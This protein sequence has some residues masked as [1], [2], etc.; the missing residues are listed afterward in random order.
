M[1]LL[2]LESADDRGDVVHLERPLAEHAPVQ[3]LEIVVGSPG[4]TVAVISMFGDA[5]EV[6]EAER[7]RLHRVGVADR[8]GQLARIG[9]ARV[10]GREAQP[11]RRVLLPRP[12]VERLLLVVRRA[13]AGNRLVA[14]HRRPQIVRADLRDQVGDGDAVLGLRDVVEARVVHQRRRVA[15]LLD[16][17]LVADLLGGI[18]RARLH[19]VLEAERV[20]DFV[21]GDVFD[22]PAHQIVGQRQLRRA[23]IE[24]ARPARNTSRAPGS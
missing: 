23:R 9:A 20:A 17:L 19:V 24:R 7:R 14:P 4:L 21:R 18:H 15:H 1:P 11:R 6:L 2:R 13:R 5:L 8:F 22:Q 16:P 12:L 10:G 3:L